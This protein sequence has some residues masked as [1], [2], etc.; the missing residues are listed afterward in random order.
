MKNI[1]KKWTVWVLLVILLSSGLVTNMSAETVHAA[2][3]KKITASAQLVCGK[4][5]M[6]KVPH[7][8]KRCR[9]SSSNKKVA[10]VAANGSV[11]ALRLGVTKISIKSGNKKTNYTITVVPEKKSDVHLNQE[12]I[13]C[14]QNIQLKLVSD[15]YDT[16]QVKLSFACDFNEISKD[17]WWK[18]NDSS[19]SQEKVYIQYSYGTFSSGVYIYVC[20]K[21][22][23]FSGLL[24]TDE[25][26]QK[27]IYA[28]VKY[29]RDSL[30]W[31]FFEDKP[32]TFRQIKQ[33]GIR[34]EL[35]GKELPD[36]IVYMPGEHTFTIIA[37]KQVYTKNIS[38]SYSVKD[39]LIKRDATGFSEEG[40]AVFDAAFHAVEQNISEGMSEEQKVKAIHD[41]LIYSANYVNNGNYKS[42]EKWA[43]GAGGVLIHKEGVCQSYAIAFYMMAV[44]SGLDCRYVTGTAKGGGHAWNQVKVDGTW[45]YIDC[46]WDDPIMNGHSGGGERYKYYL[47]ENGWS[48]HTVG[49]VKDLADAGISF[50]EKYYLTGEGYK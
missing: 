21:E 22:F 2:S 26:E 4:T 18:W 1:M 28:G 17:G 20:D 36:E 37:G 30:K 44:A 49:T 27:N 12:V 23:L 31:K 47:S 9:F 14:K 48:N 43:Y 13:I 15:K 5:G 6:I 45:Y 10:T 35:D 16:S 3:T 34:I 11:K 8:Y 42:A 32:M 38:V 50:W 39:A 46:T 33:K 29:K 7:G 40:K 41:Y 19:Y 24:N 25:W